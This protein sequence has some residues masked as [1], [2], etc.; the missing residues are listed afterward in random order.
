[1]ATSYEQAKQPAVVDPQ[2][3]VCITHSYEPLPALLMDQLTRALT[4]TLQKAAVAAIKRYML[5][6]KKLLTYQLLR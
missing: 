6:N 2:L 1:M 4:T 3:A 5:F